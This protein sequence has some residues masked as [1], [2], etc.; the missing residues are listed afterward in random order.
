MQFSIFFLKRNN[1]SKTLQI[2]AQKGVPIFHLSKKETTR[3]KHLKVVFNFWKFNN[4]FNIIITIDRIHYYF[5]TV[6]SKTDAFQRKIK[7]EFDFF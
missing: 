4:S 1:Y 6:K 5:F 2:T 3:K 7:I